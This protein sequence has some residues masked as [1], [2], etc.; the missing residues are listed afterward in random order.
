MEQWQPVQDFEGFYEVSDAGRIKSLTRKAGD[1]RTVK[2]RFLKMSP[3]SSGHIRVTLYRDGVAHRF[4]V[5][6]LVAFAFVDGDKTLNVLHK[7]GDPANNRS[8]NLKWGTQ[9]DNTKD[10]I[11]H[12]TYKNANTFK[13]HCPRG[14]EY[15]DE[16]TYVNPRG[17]RECRICRDE[18]V[19]N[20][21]L[22][23]KAVS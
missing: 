16:N 1:G 7:N 15:T 12:G 3:L 20:Y 13:T 8:S 4:L 2:E 14:H 22:K 10:A 9:S 17:S 21:Y 18:R 6:R 23:K 19:R 5:H 11:R